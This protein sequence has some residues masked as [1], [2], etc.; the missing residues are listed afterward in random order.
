MQRPIFFK[1]N[2]RLFSLLFGAAV[3]F[4]FSNNAAAD[5]LNCTNGNTL[6]STWQATFN[7]VQDNPN[8][9]IGG[10]LATATVAVVGGTQAIV[11]CGMLPG[12]GTGTTTVALR[13]E[14]VGDIRSTNIGGAS[15]R[16]LYNGAQLPTSATY[17]SFS[18]AGNTT[19]TPSGLTAQ[20]I[21]TAANPYLA[22]GYCLG[23]D[24]GG[25]LAMGNSSRYLA[26][27]TACVSGFTS[28]VPTCNVNTGSVNIPLGN[29]AGSS[30][31]N[32]GSFTTA[33]A[34]QNIGLSCSYSPRVRMTLQGTQAAGGPNTTVALTGAGGAGVA[35]GIGVQVLYGGNP[36]VVNSTTP[37]V[38]SAAA[39]A[40][41]NVPVTAR[42][43]RTGTVVAGRANASPTLRFDYN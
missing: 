10:V 42:Y 33:P 37:T 16:F 23:Q 20:L 28:A 14:G 9:P 6:L 18:F 34:T 21:K 31:A 4:G 13:R 25:R 39:G 2:C 32:V 29:V 11:S 8:I 38:V 19:L 17:Q 40:T 30:F 41:L 26:N 43:Y 7:N 36:L 22:S 12:T 5:Y 35:Q 24:I 15:I 1:S 3:L 27:I